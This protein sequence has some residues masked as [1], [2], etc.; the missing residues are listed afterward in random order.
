MSRKTR[1]R[2]FTFQEKVLMFIKKTKPNTGKQALLLAPFLILVLVVSG[3]MGRTESTKVEANA[4]PDSSSA[5][6]VT[7]VGDVMLGRYVKEVSNRYG[8]E[9]IFRHVKPFFNQSDYVIGNYETP[10]LKYNES[11]YT[12][13]EGAIE[14]STDETDVQ[15][16]KKA[17]FNVVSLANNYTMTHGPKA[18]R[19]TIDV[20]KK[21]KI[22]TVGAGTNEEEAKMVSYKE[23]DGVRIASV[24]F[25]DTFSASMVAGK[26]SPG[27]LPANPNYIFEVIQQAK[28]NADLVLVNAHWGQEYDV[29]PSLR[30]QGLAKAMVDA[31]ADIIVGHHPH[32]LQSVDVYKGSVIFYSLGNFVFDQ[33]WSSTKN[34]ALVQYHLNQKGQVKIDIIPMFIKEGTPRQTTSAWRMKRIYN[35][36]TKYTSAG[37]HL[38]KTGDKFQIKLDHSHV[39]ESVEQRQKVAETQTVE[40]QAEVETTVQ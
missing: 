22:D 14:L 8:D 29:E 1:Y 39:M 2:K 6:T 38:K 25:T 33:G 28:A 17:G 37:V 24:G 31:G 5:V 35:D 19:E 7:M 11:S 13:V 34:T 18:M 9:F 3:W 16:I 20:F 27:V 12:T 36:L 15:A 21:Y 4:T 40:N 30:Q 26:T 32:V 23:V 10:V